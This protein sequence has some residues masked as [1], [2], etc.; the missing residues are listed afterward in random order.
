MAYAQTNCITHTTLT[1]SDAAILSKVR[2]DCP[3]LPWKLAAEMISCVQRVTNSIMGMDSPKCLE[4]N[5][6]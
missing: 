5:K 1:C 2:L 3:M 4:V 6:S